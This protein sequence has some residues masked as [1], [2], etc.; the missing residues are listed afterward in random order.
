MVFLSFS[1]KKMWLIDVLRSNEVQIVY[2]IS[3]FR[4]WLWYTIAKNKYL[5]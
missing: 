2:S 1:I 4:R 3:L 5:Q